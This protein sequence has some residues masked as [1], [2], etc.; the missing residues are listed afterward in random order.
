MNKLVDD[1]YN[2][3]YS[4]NI[5][6]LPIGLKGGHAGLLLFFSL[7][8]EIYQKQEARDKAGKILQYCLSRNPERQ[9]CTLSTGYLGIGWAMRYLERRDILESDSLL[10]EIYRTLDYSCFLYFSAFPLKYSFPD[11]MFS[12]GLYFLNPVYPVDTV[13]FYQHT[14]QLLK[15]IEECDAL[16][17]RSI[18]DIY[19]PARMSARLFHSIYY[20]LLETDKRGIYPVKTRQLLHLADRLYTGL[21]NKEPYDSF[22]TGRLRKEE[23]S[24]PD[25]AWDFATKIDFLSEMGYYSVL[26]E[27]PSIFDA[28]LREFEKKD[29][30][31]LSS[32]HGEIQKGETGLSLLCGLALGFVHSNYLHY[33]IFRP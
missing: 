22:V 13:A 5:S 29:P 17:N 7:Y 25:L 19:V 16:L 15:L 20:F 3:L 1:I 24:L 33:E 12:V 14:E 23:R 27:N 10:Q 6:S 9:P 11:D 28:A 4:R 31:I 21:K 26:Y 8:S 32:L 18:A 30:R 2:Q